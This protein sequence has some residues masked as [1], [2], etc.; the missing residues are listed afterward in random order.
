MTLSLPRQ[1]TTERFGFGDNWRRFLAT[2]NEDRL[3]QAESSLLQALER[4]NLEGL[5]FVDVGCGSGL[6]SLAAARLGATVHSFDFDPL[7]M[8]CAISLRI[9]FAIPTERWTIEQGSALDEPYLA[10]LGQFDIVYSWGVL[11]HTGA[12]W[13]ALENVTTLVAPK[14]QLCVAI[15]NDQ[16]SGSQRWLAIKR[17]YNRAP[18]PL[19]WATVL[20]TGAI[21]EGRYA[22]GRLAKGQNPLP[23]KEWKQRQS[24]R[25]M[26]VWYDLVDWVG[27]YPFEVARPEEIFDFYR[28][29]GFRL[30]TLKTC[31]GGLGC[32]EFVFQRENI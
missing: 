14:G 13:K 23:F 4:P 32:N 15:Y 25:G 21:L 24:S 3:R 28:K 10:K 27:G 8:E 17:F 30:Q 7:A 29:R 19:R 11:H 1:E 6:F 26:S 18:A 9:R 2:F 20:A 22:L 12:M 5:R 16:G 31:G